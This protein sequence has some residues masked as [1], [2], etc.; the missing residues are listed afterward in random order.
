MTNQPGTTIREA[1]PDDVDVL[2]KFNAAMA[3]ETEGKSLDVERL[4]AGVG[5]VFE[6]SEKGFYV[7][8]EVEGSVVGSLLITYEWSD[9]RDATFWWIQ[10]VYVRPDWRRRGIYRAMHDWV[11]AAARSHSDVCGIRLYVDLD[12]QIAQNTYANL[13][14]V[15]AHYHLFEIDFVYRT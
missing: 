6:A 1:R 3:K 15:R 4:T 7:V 10:S 5:A 13:G 12:N 11:Y 14:M 2:V 8:A 9:W